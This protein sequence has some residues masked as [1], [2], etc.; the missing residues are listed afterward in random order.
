MLIDHIWDYTD[1]TYLHNMSHLREIQ[2]H[3]KIEHIG[4]TNVDAAHLELLLHSGF[5]IASNQVSCSIL[6]R[7]FERGRL[8][9]LCREHSVSILAYGVLLGG[10][11]SENWLGQPEPTDM[12]QLNWSLRKYLRFIRAAGGWGVFQEVLRAVA[13]IAKKYAVSIAAVAMRYVL[14]IPGVSAIIIGTRLSS[15]S[16][17]YL[18][19]LRSTFSLKLDVDD[20]KLL[21]E[22]EAKLKDIP[23]DCGDEY[24]RPPFLTAAGDLSHHLPPKDDMTKLQD[25]ISKN[26]RIE[27]SSGGKFEAIAV[28]IS[29]LRDMVV[30]DR[31]KRAIAEQ[32]VLGKR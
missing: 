7:R 21:A 4:L 29:P 1:D 2:S 3:G 13:A 32:S 5:R 26:Y 18:A 27:Y 22:A 30:A 8:G 23:G 6:D 20:R 24:R 25:A 15:E 14:D 17:K 11:V 19:R 12:D 31:Q 28:G 9:K 16:E 10:F